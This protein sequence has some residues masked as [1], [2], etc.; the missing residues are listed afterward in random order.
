MSCSLSQSAVRISP[1]CY[2][3]RGME[4]SSKPHSPYHYWL[5]SVRL[6]KNSLFPILHMYIVSHGASTDR[7]WNMPVECINEQEMINTRWLDFAGTNK[8]SIRQEETTSR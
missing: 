8:Q 1:H 3:S 5:F 2:S 6:L 4:S 7:T